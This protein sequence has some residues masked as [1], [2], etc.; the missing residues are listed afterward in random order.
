VKVREQENEAGFT[1]DP[2]MWRW[3][4]ESGCVSVKEDSFIMKLTVI[5]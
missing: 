4:S 5:G 1:V 3:E 2:K